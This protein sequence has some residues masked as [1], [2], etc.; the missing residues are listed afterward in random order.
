[1]AENI[2][3]LIEPSG[4]FTGTTVSRVHA[5]VSGLGKA[6]GVLAMTRVG[7]VF[8]ALALVLGGIYYFSAP[9]KVTAPPASFLQQGTAGAVK[10]PASASPRLST[11]DEST[12]AAELDEVPQESNKDVT[13]KQN[14]IKKGGTKR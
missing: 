12:R 2:I 13:T 14:K 3:R 5:S 1:M 7:A 9:K 11:Q 10:A 4:R 6:K 8:V